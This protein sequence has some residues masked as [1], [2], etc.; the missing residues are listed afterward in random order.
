MIR[1]ATELLDKGRGSAAR[2]P[3]R[4]KKFLRD[5]LAL[6]DRRD[7]GKISEHG[8]VV[9]RGH[10]EERLDELLARKYS[11]KDNRR[12]RK[13]LAKHLAKH[14]REILT[15]LY[16]K[17]ID[18]TNWPAEQAMRPAVGN[19]KLFGGN[20]TW[21]AAAARERLGSL[22]A[23]CGK[24]AIESLATLSHIICRPILAA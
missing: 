16:H 8:L 15:F 6:R 3:N 17:D 10:L 9:A 14:R 18:A 1:R 20:R 5:A 21:S 12:F 19:R 11:H 23:T 7:A 4:V 24:N 2:F 13:H 22:F